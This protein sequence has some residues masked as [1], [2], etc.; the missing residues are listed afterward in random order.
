MTLHQLMRNYVSVERPQIEPR[1]R[2]PI[3][4][5]IDEGLHRCYMGQLLTADS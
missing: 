5:L 1:L 3:R 2:P 4:L